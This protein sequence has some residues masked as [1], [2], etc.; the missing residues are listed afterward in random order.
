MFCDNLQQESIHKVCSHRPSFIHDL[1]L[2]KFLP[3]LLLPLLLL[4]VS[5]LVW[6][7]P[8][9]HNS[10]SAGFGKQSTQ[11]PLS[12]SVETEGVSAKVTHLTTPY[13]AHPSILFSSSAK[14]RGTCCFVLFY[15][16][17]HAHV[18]CLLQILYCV[19]SNTRNRFA[20]VQPLC[21]LQDAPE[22]KLYVFKRLIIT[23]S[24]FFCLF[25]TFLPPQGLSLLLQLFFL[26]KNVEKSQSHICSHCTNP[27]VKTYTKH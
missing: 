16:Q 2:L 24:F 6:G 20:Y 7:H 19:S 25:F 10:A 9:P 23:W 21:R 11:R 27:Q 12:V 17:K 5:Y 13:F 18:W 3:T 26:E 1:R 4:P 15:Y 8:A 22:Q 14:F